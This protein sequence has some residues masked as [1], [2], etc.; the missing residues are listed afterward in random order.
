[1]TYQAG[2]YELNGNLY[3]VFVTGRVDVIVPVRTANRS[4]VLRT[5]KQD[6]KTAVTVRQMAVR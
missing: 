2:R 4:E 1:M 5:I 3:Q 6:G